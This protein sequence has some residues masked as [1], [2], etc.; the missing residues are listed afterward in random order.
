MSN[1]NTSNVSEAS[2]MDPLCA[3]LIGGIALTGHV[4]DD[5]AA[6][7][8]AHGRA[9]TAAHCAA[10]AGEARRLA[11]RFGANERRAE[12]AGWLHDISAVIPAAQRLDYARQWRLEIQPEEAAAPMLLHQRQS[13]VLAAEVFGVS[14]P[15]ILSAIGCH[16][17]LKAS[18][19]VL[20]KVVFLADK[21]AWDGVGAPPYQDAIL[22]A[23][24]ASLDE[25]CWCYLDYLWSRRATL[26]AVHPWF[27]TAYRELSAHLGRSLA[28]ADL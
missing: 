2:N 14:D 27:V 28:L 11:A 13:A 4:P 19:S 18:P 17:T 21:I 8:N 9:E 25:A 23:V 1:V 10:V 22:R 15:A 12:T 24:E 6:L 3:A 16:T 7:L 20:D 26:F 5:A